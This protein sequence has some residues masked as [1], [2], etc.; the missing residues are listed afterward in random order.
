MDVGNVASL[1]PS[2]VRNSQRCILAHDFNNNL[3]VILGRCEM[4]G[5]LLDVNDD[6]NVESIKHVRLIKEA[7]IHMARAIA[8]RPCQFSLFTIP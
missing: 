2:R 1:T 3:H 8:E 4:L 5:D 6:R 7:V